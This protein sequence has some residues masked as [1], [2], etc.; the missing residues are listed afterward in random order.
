MCKHLLSIGAGL[1]AALFS[2]TFAGAHD[3][4]LVPE[5]FTVSPRAKV[6]VALNTGDTFPVSESAVKPE[7]I[8]RASLVTSDG[9]T[10]V[11]ASRTAGTS[12]VVDVIAP[13]A[14]GGMI[15]EVVL[16]PVTTKQ[17]RDGFDEFIKHEGLDRVAELLA[18]EPSRREAESRVYAKY[19]KTL[20]RVGKRRKG[21]T[22]YSK[23][24]GHRLEIVPEADP[25]SLKA[26]GEF[27]VRLLFDGKPLALARL[28]VGSAAAETAKQSTMPGVRTDVGGRAVP[29]LEGSPG[30]HYVHA[31]HMIPAE[32]RTDVQW[33]TFWAT[34]TFEPGR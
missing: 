9:S 6:A 31:V 21:A 23:P 15:V 2:A 12:T 19:A 20:L 11:P 17:P 16:K 3:L 28:V 4:W 1:S 10:P 26:G 27:P 8:E 33:E 32:G 7:R 14:G 5:Q 22:L 34:L 18:R 30:P 29:R 13:R 24:L 25:F